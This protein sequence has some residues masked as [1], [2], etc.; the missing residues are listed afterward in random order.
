MPQGFT[1]F[2]PVLDAVFVRGIDPST[3]LRRSGLSRCWREPS[4]GPT[5]AAMTQE[6]RTIRRVAVYCGSSNAAAEPFFEAAREVGRRCAEAGIGVVYGGGN[7]GLMGACADAAL[8][9]GGEVIGVIPHRIVELEVA[10]TGLSELIKVDSMHARKMVM[11]SLS[12]AFVALPGGFGT[13]DEIFEAT[14]W[15]Q[16]GYHCKP[17]GLLNTEGYFDHLLAFMQRA[18]DEGFV[19]PVH[20]HLLFSRDTPEQ[21]LEGLRT[22]EMA[23][24]RDWKV[25]P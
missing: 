23:N 3:L 4:E 8:A 17:A 14:T 13:L 20:Q 6:K 15:N 10:H 25:K 19:R 18:I 21:L 12:D 9:A 5:P 1:V 22:V 2:E 24:L 16:L 7:M 11:A